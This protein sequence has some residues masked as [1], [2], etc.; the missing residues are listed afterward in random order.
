M[1]FSDLF[2]RILKYFCLVFYIV[3]Y[4]K[5]LTL[6]VMRA[7]E[8]GNR[9]RRDFGKF[10]YILFVIDDFQNR[11]SGFIFVLLKCTHVY[12]RS[13]FKGSYPLQM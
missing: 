5:S 4:L 8:E 9:V 6:K 7:V 1:D 11:C 12:I 3:S 10:A 13:K 2:T